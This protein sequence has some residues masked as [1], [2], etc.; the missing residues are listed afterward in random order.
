[1]LK[2]WPAREQDLLNFWLSCYLDLND[3]S[4]SVAQFIGS[5]V[6]CF[7]EGIIQFQ[8]DP[9]QGIRTL[10]VPACSSTPVLQGVLSPQARGLV[11]THVAFHYLGQGWHQ[12]IH[13]VLCQGVDHEG[14]PL[15]EE[16]GTLGSL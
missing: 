13:N 15:A 8:K 5:V 16:S 3:L 4:G 1:M 2:S 10:M 7:V 14:E 6:L 11:F 12:E 9:T